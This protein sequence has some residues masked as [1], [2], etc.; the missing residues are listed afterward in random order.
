[1]AGDERHRYLS[2]DRQ[3]YLPNAALIRAR[4]KV[5]V[6]T[7]TRTGQ[8]KIFISCEI[9]ALDARIEALVYE[10]YGLIE[11]EIALVER[12]VR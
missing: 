11:E 4:M 10:L 12:A 8:D 2:F 1:M 5:E 6:E 3:P 7:G 9:E